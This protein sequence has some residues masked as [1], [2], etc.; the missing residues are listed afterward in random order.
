[1]EQLSFFNISTH[2]FEDKLSSVFNTIITK[3]ELPQKTFEIAINTGKSGKETSRSICIVE[4][5][6]PPGLG[7]ASRNT[8]ILRYKYIYSESKEPMLQL[9]VRRKQ[10]NHIVLPDTCLEVKDMES[11]NASFHVYFCPDDPGILNYIF[12]IA[13]YN[14]ENYESTNSF[15]CCSKYAACSAKRKCIHD[16]NLYAKGCFYRKNLEKGKIF[17]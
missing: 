6:Y 10:F 17:Y 14:I 3:Y 5:P 2:S 1:M 15:G 16:N 11:D 13:C 4:P 8:V 9:F 7:M 12:D